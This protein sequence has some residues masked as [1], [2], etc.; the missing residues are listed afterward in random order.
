M[1]HALLP[2]VLVVPLVAAC[3]GSTSS[4]QP[5]P[6]GGSPTPAPTRAAIAPRTP[7]ASCDAQCQVLALQSPGLSAPGP[8]P[9]GDY[10]TKAFFP[11]G[12]TVTLDAGWSSHEDSTGEFSLERATAPDDNLVFWLDM[13]PTTWD[14]KPVDGIA[15]TPEAVSA[16]LHDQDALTV[17]PARA[18]TV[19]EAGLPA[20][21]MDI[22][23]APDA[24]NGDP[25]CPT[26][27]CAAIFTWPQFPEPWAISDDMKVR[28]YLTRIGDGPHMLYAVFNVLDAD[29]F[30]PVAQPVL[31]SIV[32]SHDLD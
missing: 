5:P 9:A 24:P 4:T 21:V 11:G 30:A 13:T 27:S 8:L 1:R 15:N 25:G 32:L 7:D 14:A 28:L 29:A 23:V 2:F 20:L 31:D 3:G 16:W 22:A 26:R 19:G 18:T 10:T 12:L 17:T 6:P